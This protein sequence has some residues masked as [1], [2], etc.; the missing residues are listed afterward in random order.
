[1]KKP[2]LIEACVE[3]LKSAK[4][5]EK[6]GADRIELCSHLEVGGLTPEF[7]LIKQVK[8]SLT[9][10][11][12][13]MIRPREGDFY[14][15]DDEVEDMIDSISMCRYLDVEGVVFGATTSSMK[16]LDMEL[17]E[18]L[19][20]VAYPLKVT[21][22]KAID[23]CTFPSKE[24]FKLKNIRNIDAV[25]SSGKKDTA[26]EGFEELKLMINQA[27]DKIKI[28]SAGKITSENLDEVHDKIGGT[29]YHGR[30]IVQVF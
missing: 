26:I 14:Y 25:L 22:H 12:R 10:P 21:I 19:A 2:Y 16:K 7:T 13:V 15:S 4:N 1:M 23:E 11:I 5:A 18:E 17:I 29:Y 28:I 6:N 8:S 20:A 9:I 24:V 27:S 30:K 3:S